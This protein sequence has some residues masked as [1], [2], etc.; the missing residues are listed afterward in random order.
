MDLFSQGQYFS[1]H[2]LELAKVD[3]LVK[4]SVCAVAAKQMG[5]M[6]EPTSRVKTTTGQMLVMKAIDSSQNDYLW[7]GAK[8]YERAIQMLA[9]EIRHHGTNGFPSSLSDV[10]RSVDGSQA[11]GSPASARSDSSPLVAACLLIE[12][13]RLS[14]TTRA[15][16][17]HVAGMAKL[18]RLHDPDAFTQPS[19]AIESGHTEIS[20]TAIVRSFFW[21]FA[22][23]DFESSRKNRWSCRISAQA[24][25]T[26]WLAG[27]RHKRTP[28]TMFFGQEWDCPSVTQASG[29]LK[30]HRRVLQPLLDSVLKTSRSTNSSGSCAD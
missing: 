6:A 16:C 29:L 4:F 17:G 28:R 22:F 10:Y 1:H 30:S 18:L 25:Q 19:P 14:A 12:Y 11:A 24:N 8:Y 20:R 5:Q 15:W 7:Y 23:N 27:H 21:Y 9:G 3:T 13:E 26:Q 2:V